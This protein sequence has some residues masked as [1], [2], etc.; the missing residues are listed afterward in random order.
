MGVIKVADEIVIYDSAEG[1]DLELVYPYCISGT[2]GD[3]VF[4]RALEL[5][6]STVRIRGTRHDVED[7]E[8]AAEGEFLEAGR[9]LKGRPVTNWCHGRYVIYL[10]SIT[11]AE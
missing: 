5:Q 6:N 9:K 8:S 11:K 2:G 4:Q 7:L 1:R 10:T 3:E